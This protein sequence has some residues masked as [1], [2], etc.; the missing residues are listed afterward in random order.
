MCRDEG[1][2]EAFEAVT[3]VSSWGSH[4]V[5][6]PCR[7]LWGYT[8]MKMN[9]N[10]LFPFQSPAQVQHSWEE[11]HVVVLAFTTCPGF[12]FAK[13]QGVGRGALL[14]SSFYSGRGALPPTQSHTMDDISKIKE[15]FDMLDRQR[16][17]ERGKEE[18]NQGEK[19]GMRK[20]EEK[21]IEKEKQ[22][23]LSSILSLLG[24]CGVLW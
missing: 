24:W 13:W 19:Q 11:L 6:S 17:R 22:F 12:V 15:V 18:G 23:T 1:I 8:A 21:E 9:S 5:L 7:V 10:Y 14:S 3:V 20:E 4:R 2:S 16:K